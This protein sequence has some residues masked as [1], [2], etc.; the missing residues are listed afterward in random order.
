M[1]T[2]CRPHPER[3]RP[4]ACFLPDM[5]EAECDETDNCNKE[6]EIFEPLYGVGKMK[7]DINDTGN[8]ACEQGYGDRDIQ[9]YIAKG[10]YCPYSKGFEQQDNGK[11]NK[12]V[13]EFV[14]MHAITS[15]RKS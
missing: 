2:G 13:S 1:R 9:Q 8:V 7:R 14:S 11:S 5:T 4:A 12:K 6:C 15:Y 3:V 10:A